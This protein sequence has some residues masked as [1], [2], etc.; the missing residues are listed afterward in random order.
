[1]ARARVEDLFMSSGAGDPMLR[2]GVVFAEQGRGLRGDRYA[3]GEGAWSKKTEKVRQVSLIAAEAI[4]AANDQLGHADQFAYADTRRNI[5]T[6]GINLEELL[7]GQARVL[8]IGGAVLEVTDDCAPCHR[9]D[10]LAGKT[11]FKGAFEGRGGV[12]AR[13]LES[14]LIRIEDQIV[15]AQ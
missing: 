1:M 8:K 9:P 10:R 2:Y 3:V 14:G 5:I 7:V 4:A 15:I 6:R 12:R 11:G 13:V